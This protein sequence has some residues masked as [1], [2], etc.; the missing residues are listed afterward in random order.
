MSFDCWSAENWSAWSCGNCL[1]ESPPYIWDVL[2]L[3]YSESNRGSIGIKRS[4][5]VSTE[6]TEDFNGWQQGQ[7]PDFYQQDD[8]PLTNTGS[9]SLQMDR[10]YPFV[11]GEHCGSIVED[12]CIGSENDGITYQDET[13]YVRDHGVDPDS[14]PMS[15]DGCVFTNLR[16][17]QV[18]RSGNQFVIAFFSNRQVDTSNWVYP[19]VMYIFNLKNGDTGVTL[20]TDDS[21]FNNGEPNSPYADFFTLSPTVVDMSVSTSKIV[22]IEGVYFPLGE[23]SYREYGIG[24]NE[25]IVDGESSPQ[26]VNFSSENYTAAW[27]LDDNLSTIEIR[28]QEKKAIAKKNGEEDVDLGYINVYSNEHAAYDVIDDFNTANIISIVNN[29]RTP[30]L[31]T[32]TINLVDKTITKDG[33]V[34]DRVISY[35]PP[36]VD[37][38]I[39]SVSIKGPFGGTA[40]MIVDI[41]SAPGLVPTDSAI[42]SFSTLF[43]I[44][45]YQKKCDHHVFLI[46]TQSDDFNNPINTHYYDSRNTGNPINEVPFANPSYIYIGPKHEILMMN[47]QTCTRLNGPAGPEWTITNDFVNFLVGDRGCDL[48]DLNISWTRGCT[49]SSSGNG[50]YQLRGFPMDAGS[51]KYTSYI[52]GAHKYFEGF[53]IPGFFT[54]SPTDYCFQWHISEDGQQRIPHSALGSEGPSESYVSPAPK[55]W[56]HPVLPYDQLSNSAQTTHI[57]ELNARGGMGD[58]LVQVYRFPSSSSNINIYARLLARAG[59][60]LIAAP[61]KTPSETSKLC[62]RC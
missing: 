37:Q 40:T 11:I 5:A 60:G 55:T 53:A 44:N 22:Y 25:Y 20:F 21:L 42:V 10:F 29:P 51:S 17:T 1:T 59:S 14:D 31:G 38:T 36:V 15:Y 41:S 52:H 3:T 16:L 49:I 24:I 46:A 6:L 33:V 56:G 26:I 43:H 8:L 39:M 47:W 34:F 13:L 61:L 35:V 28:G 4:S 58:E 9:S 57:G 45:C 23:F 19:D 32:Y 54:D 30:V 62:S 50:Y 18:D 12:A 2:S 27:C 48:D 7:T